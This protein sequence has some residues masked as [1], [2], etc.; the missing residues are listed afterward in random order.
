MSVIKKGAG[1]FC[2]VACA[3][4][5]RPKRKAY[6]VQRICLECKKH[7]L[8]WPRDVRNN[9]GKYC[10]LRCVGKMVWKNSVIREKILKTRRINPA[11]YWL[12]KKRPD[13]GKKVAKK[14]KGRKMNLTKEQRERRSQMSKKNGFQRGHNVSLEIKDKLRMARMKQVLPKKNTKIEIVIQNLLKQ[15][16]ILFKK[17]KSLENICI[18]D[19]FIPSMKKVVF[20]DGDYWHNLP[21][22][23]ERDERQNKILTEKGYKVVRLWEHEI[24]KNPLRCL[25]KILND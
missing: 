7:F 14:L 19:I 5:G 24:N 1:K 23:K 13:I 3:V 18:A 12:G 21:G 16:N 2:S 15:N 22:Y 10:S 25:E 11:R 6:K 8:V 9:R 20:C 17:Q 4:I